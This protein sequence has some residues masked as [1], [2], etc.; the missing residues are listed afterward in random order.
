[1]APS[2]KIGAEPGGANKLCPI[3]QYFDRFYFCVDISVH[4]PS[5]R[6]R[7]GVAEH[8]LRSGHGCLGSSPTFAILFFFFI[9]H[10]KA[11]YSSK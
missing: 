10:E 5:Y 6:S 8:H 2:I 3:L 7:S 4:C 11:E 9:L 1:M